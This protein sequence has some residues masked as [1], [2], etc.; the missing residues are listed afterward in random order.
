MWGTRGKM[1]ANVAI[2]G[3]TRTCPICHA[4]LSN[5]EMGVNSHI[6]THV[7][8]KEIKKSEEQ[9]LRLFILGRTFKRDS[10]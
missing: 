10:A 3:V 2:P 8:K 1:S 6:R 7:R 4:L 9:E 5:A